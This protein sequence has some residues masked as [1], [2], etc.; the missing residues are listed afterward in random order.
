MKIKILDSVHC[1]ILNKKDISLIKPCLSYKAE[2]WQ[3]GPY[4]K[5]R[6]E[7]MA[8]LVDKQGIFL[9]GFIPRVS[10]YAKEQGITMYWEGSLPSFN[11]TNPP[12][13][14]GIDL[15]SDQID[16]IDRALALQ[17]GMIKAPT[18]IGKTILALGFLSCFPGRNVLFLCRE[19]GLMDQTFM[20]MQRFHFKN[21]GRYGDSLKELKPITIAIAQSFVKIN[22]IKYCSYFDIVIVDEADVGIGIDSQYYKILTRML[23]PI[24]IGLSATLPE[25]ESSRLIMEGLLGPVIGEMTVQEGIESNLLAKPKI[26][27]IRIPKDHRIR[28]Y[29]TYFDVYQY[30]IVERRSRN[31]LIINTAIE[32]IKQGKT[33]LILVTKVEHGQILESIARERGMKIPFVYGATDTS[34]RT[35]IK[36]DLNKKKIPCVI[37]DVVWKRGVNIPS[38]DVIIN[39][40]GEK[41]ETLTLQKIGRGLRRTDEKD[42]VIIVDFFDDSHFY[43][44]SHFGFRFSLYCE[45]GWI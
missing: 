24:R 25:K 43:L 22:P 34:D 4:R 27:I 31:E 18:G 23:A 38:L 2:F 33:C 28:E 30:G 12:Y 6:K 41:S 15:R 40:A 8:S 9:S 36:L 5:V 19:K 16:L 29:R 3:Q 14:K 1:Q 39:A 26:R 20:E 21:V 44:I 45:Q 32:Y 42:E 13:L 37:A 11:W 17:R 7:Y 35:E 10:Q